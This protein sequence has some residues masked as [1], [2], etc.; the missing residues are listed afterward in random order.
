[1]RFQIRGPI[2]TDPDIVMVNAD[3][4]SAEVYGRK[5]SR[6]VH[7]DMIDFLRQENSSVTVYDILFAFPDSVDDGGFQRL[8]EATKNNARVIYPVSVDF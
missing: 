6:S 2:T 3:D 1:M 4:P 5:W 8:V 7:A